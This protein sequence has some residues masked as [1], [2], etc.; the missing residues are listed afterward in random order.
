[1][2]LRILVTGATSGIGLAAA[3]A[4]AARG[5]PGT[6]LLVHGRDSERLAATA[7]ET[8]ATALRADLLDLADVERLARDA[9]PVAVLVNNAGAVFA[10]HARTPDGHER[11]WQLNHLAAVALTSALGPSRVV[12]VASAAH[13]RARIHWED[14]DALAGWPAYKQSKLANVLFTRA[15]AARGTHAVALDP[16]VVDTRFAHALPDGDPLRRR[17]LGQHRGDAA[18]P[19]TTLA[20]LAL[21]ELDPAPGAYVGAGGGAG[22]LDPAARDDEAA[23]RLWALSRASLAP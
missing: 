13:R 8:G 14:P 19:G 9:R 10:E 6:T 2:N 16:G 18:L 17:L 15:L 20:R 21:N 7:R 12:T 22:K 5:V 3:R 11:T 4:I 1:M 23:D